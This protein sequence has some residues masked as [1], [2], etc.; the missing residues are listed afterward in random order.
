MFERWT[1]RREIS[2]FF[3][4]G[5]KS[6]SE[7]YNLLEKLKPIGEK[8]LK[9]IVSALQSY[10]ERL[11]E[12][13]RKADESSSVESLHQLSKEIKNLY[14]EIMSFLHQLKYLA[15]IRPEELELATRNLV[16]YCTSGEDVLEIIPNAEKVFTVILA[17]ICNDL[18][19]EVGESI[20]LV[21]QRLS[22]NVDP[23]I[24]RPWREFL[25]KDFEKVRE[26]RLNLKE[27]EGKNIVN[28]CQQFK[29]IQNIKY[30]VNILRDNVSKYENFRDRY[31][32]KSRLPHLVP[33]DVFMLVDS[34]GELCEMFSGE[35]RQE[36]EEL[37]YLS[38]ADA[39]AFL[40][41]IAECLFK[42]KRWERSG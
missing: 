10:E 42:L 38:G 17:G 5:L 18:L 37:A 26:N 3:M 21:E 35:F 12:A 13:R 7:A 30:S 9:Y 39:D 41:A 8:E 15:G 40:K 25:S 14:G 4:E 29:K 23:C 2:R 19:K 32:S 33:E 22:I 20:Q 1:L 31:I 36:V 27:N 6:L 24:E 34:P 11:N 28:I 16:E